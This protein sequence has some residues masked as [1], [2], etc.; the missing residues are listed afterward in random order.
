MRPGDYQDVA[1]GAGPLAQADKGGDLVVEVDQVLFAA[2]YRGVLGP[3]QKEAERAGV[4]RR[5][6][7]MGRRA[8]HGA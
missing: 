1:G 4:P 6:V 8:M 5:C 3:F 2:A 7:A